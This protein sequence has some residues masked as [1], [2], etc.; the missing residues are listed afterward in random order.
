M[1]I[2]FPRTLLTFCRLMITIHEWISDEKGNPRK[3]ASPDDS[4]AG[5]QQSEDLISDHKGED[6]MKYEM[7][8]GKEL[9]L[10]KEQEK[11]LNTPLLPVNFILKV[12][13][14]MMDIFYGKKRTFSKFKIIEILARYPY[15]AWEMYAYKFFTRLYTLFY[16][17]DRFAIAKDLITFTDMA[18]RS[19]DNEQY[20]LM[21]LDELMEQQE[22][23]LGFF[24]GTLL[25]RAMSWS[26]YLL[27]LLLMA[28]RPAWSYS[29]NA[30]FESHAEHEYMKLVSEHP[31]WEN[32]PVDLNSFAYY[33]KQ[34]SLADLMLRIGLDER[35]HM[36]ESML[37]YEKLTGRQIKNRN[38][39]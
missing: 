21:I 6:I 9:D 15:R 23:K 38:D 18:R 7:T 30:R 31:E 37:E 22:I 12:L 28:L 25:P 36:H 24:R 4:R 2:D 19:Q 33:P 3:K 27:E 13:I 5:D 17:K 16:H 35:D 32:I 34:K 14:I 20:H 8:M 29:L 39:S 26:Y 1:S 11:T 10:K